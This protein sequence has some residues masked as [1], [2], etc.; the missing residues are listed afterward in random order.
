V[1]NDQS[2][3][4]LL[5]LLSHHVDIDIVSLYPVV[6]ANKSARLHRGPAFPSVETTNLHL[7]SA[8]DKIQGN[9]SPA[10]IVQ[11]ALTERPA[12]HVVFSTDIS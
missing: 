1:D 7:L 3:N 5:F 10:L 6:S 2:N 11:L 4:S 8:P 12:L 9:I